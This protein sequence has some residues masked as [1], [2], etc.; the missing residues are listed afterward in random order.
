[1]GKV[2]VFISAIP[3]LGKKTLKDGTQRDQLEAV[4]YEPVG[5]SKLKYG[6]ET[7]FPIVPVIN[8]Y[9]NEGDTIRVLAILADG[10]K[11]NARNIQH[12]Y[13]T[14]FVPE[15]DNIVQTKKLIFNGIEEIH[16]PDNEDIDTQLML[17]SDIADKINPGEDIYACI[18]YGTKPMPIVLSMAL[19][20]AYKLKKDVSVSCTVYGRFPHIDEEPKT[21]YIYDTTSLFY[22]DS[23][24]N[25]LA[26]MKA[27]DPVSA[28]KLM[29]GHKT[30]ED[31]SDGE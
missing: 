27:S 5:N 2:K 15:I 31:A 7:R 23:I 3:F 14:Y 26:E 16:T 21:S 20:Y 6:N 28:I 1:M 11:S 10:K 13:S 29:L 25:K 22:M 17:F 9:A 18:S 8:G 19:N 4:I 24:V 30:P 12:N